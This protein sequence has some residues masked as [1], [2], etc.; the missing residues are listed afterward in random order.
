MSTIA[1]GKTS[2]DHFPR[3]ITPVLLEC[4]EV[5]IAL[6]IMIPSAPL[7]PLVTAALVRKTLDDGGDVLRRRAATPAHEAQAE[8]A[9]ELLVR[10]G[11]FG[12]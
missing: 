5:K 2:V 7:P 6:C 9:H 10:G 8:F 1:A 3:D 4:P 11:E 12:G